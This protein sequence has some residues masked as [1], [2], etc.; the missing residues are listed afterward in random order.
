MSG[1]KHLQENTRNPIPQ[2]A[3]IIQRRGKRFAVWTKRRTKRKQRAPLS[4][5]GMAVLVEDKNYTVECFSWQ[6]KRRKTSGGERIP[7]SCTRL[8]SNGSE[9]GW[10]PNL[11]SPPTTSC[12]I[13]A[14]PGAGGERR[15]R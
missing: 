6:G 11:R 14:H 2:G 5:D 10:R 12:S 1:G 4:N 8:L 15:P 7:K 9:H 3:E 13:F